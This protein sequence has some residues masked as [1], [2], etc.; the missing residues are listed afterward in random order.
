VVVENEF[1]CSSDPSNSIYFVFSGM[2]ENLG[3]TFRVIPNPSGG[4]ISVIPDFSMSGATISVSNLM[5]DEIIRLKRNLVT[6]KA[7]TL[8]L[9]TQPA[10]IYVIR[11]HTN[12]T[13]QTCK[14]IIQ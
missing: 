3:Q 8:D 12:K 13:I 11:I 10:G 6:G 2:P 5:N 1:G 4:R 7:V 14:V 9:E